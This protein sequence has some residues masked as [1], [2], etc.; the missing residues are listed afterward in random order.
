MAE[1]DDNLSA[2]PADRLL[3]II[4]FESELADQRM[5][6]AKGVGKAR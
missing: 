4:H 1:S 6:A 3:R 5:C 2:L